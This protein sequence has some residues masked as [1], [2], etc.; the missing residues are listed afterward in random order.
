MMAWSFGETVGMIGALA[1]AG[2]VAAVTFGNDQAPREHPPLFDSRALTE[3]IVVDPPSEAVLTQRHEVK[4]AFRACPRAADWF[5]FQDAVEKQDVSVDLPNSCRMVGRGT[6]ISVEPTERRRTL[7]RKGH[8]YQQ[9]F[10]ADGTEFWTDSMDDL[11]I[12][13]L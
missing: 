5:N 7:V 8:S 4:L 3:N 2:V 9:G 10:Y 1:F 11:S 13:K 12:T 6:I